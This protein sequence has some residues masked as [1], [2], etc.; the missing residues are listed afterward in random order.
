[1]SNFKVG[2][3]NKQTNLFEAQ[4]YLFSQSISFLKH[5]FLASH[6]QLS[7]FSLFCLSPVDFK[8]T[9]KWEPET[10]H[11]PKTA[12]NFRGLGKDSWNH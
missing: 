11:H 6:T 10:I 2:M 3:K 9:K 5:P 12:M 7:S 8:T 4:F 1:M